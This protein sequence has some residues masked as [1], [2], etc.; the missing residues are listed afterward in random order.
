[1]GR[2]EAK[3]NR[4][5]RARRNLDWNQAT[6]S[7]QETVAR[8]MIVDYEDTGNWA[9]GKRKTAIGWILTSRLAPAKFL[10]STRT[11]AEGII[12]TLL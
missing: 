9:K 11:G 5:N 3:G 7:N 6:K 1:M 10:P 12:R 2:T 4:S 8:T